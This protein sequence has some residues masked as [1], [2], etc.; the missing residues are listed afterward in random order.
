MQTL[1]LPLELFQI[2]LAKAAQQPG[3]AQSLRL[4][5]RSLAHGCAAALVTG[6]KACRALIFLM[7][8]RDAAL[9]TLE[10]QGKLLCPQTVGT[11]YL[12]TPNLQCLPRR[13]FQRWLWQ[14]GVL[15]RAFPS[16]TLN[17]NAVVD[18]ADEVDI[19]RLL[20]CTELRDITIYPAPAPGGRGRQFWRAIASLGRLHGGRL[21]LLV[22]EQTTFQM[23][24]AEPSLAAHV[25]QAALAW[26]A[27]AGS[28]LADQLSS[29]SSLTKLV[30][31]SQDSVLREAG[32]LDALR[33]LSLL[34][35]LHCSASVMQLLLV[36]SVPSSWSL[37][38]KLAVSSYFEPVPLDKSLVGQQCPQL[39]ALDMNNYP[40]CL[41]AL[42]S[43][44]CNYWQPRDRDHFQYSRLVD[45]HVRRRVDPSLM[46]S[47]LTSLSVHSSAWWQFSDLDDDL[48]CPQSLVHMSFKSKLWDPSQI[49]DYLDIEDLLPASNPVLRSVTSLELAIVPEAFLPNMDWQQFHH[50]GAWFP[51]LQRLHINLGCPYPQPEEV[52]ISAA[53]LPAH[54]R[55][56][57]THQLTC[58]VRIE[59]CPS[60]YLSLPLCSRPA[61][62]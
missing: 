22:A 38:T 2:V 41:T 42:T 35:S 40:L 3:T 8:M 61:D 13:E 17:L 28:G 12:E 18:T 62:R 15:Q 44:T 46:P 32:M 49:Q 56:I 50:L 25:S 23:L 55:L 10:L 51:R 9:V 29:L 48:T 7:R 16:S 27:D 33:Q 19:H 5:S 54:C 26:S 14:V 47:T 11:L 43:L 37:L 45:L 6:G 39:Q 53:W 4:T 34:Q 52:L 1:G 31:H 60:G 20:S 30:L 24:E 36:N 21:Q 57:V 58:P 59:K